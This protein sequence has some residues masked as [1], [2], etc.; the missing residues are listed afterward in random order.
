MNS[1]KRNSARNQA[2]QESVLDTAAN[3]FAQYG[4][5]RTT[6]NDIAEA[7]GISRPALYL[8]FDNKEHLFHELAAYRINLA[9]AASEAVLKSEGSVADRFIDALMVFEKTYTE[10]VANSPHGEELIDV[11]M[12]L[13]S[14]VM[15]KGYA[16]LVSSLAK[17][18]NDAA[19]EGEVS[20][21]R[22]PMS[23]KAFVELLLASIKG[24]KTKAGTKAEYR[25]QTRQAAQIF[26]D[27]ITGNKSG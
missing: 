10:P 12:S 14:D 16:S 27:S 2:K 23:A 5:R 21:E 26:L 7:A 24:I 18:L 11:N 20:F 22:M 17:L 19:K 6:M 1:S 8:M 3:V 13:A 9:L 25:K 4:F 15:N